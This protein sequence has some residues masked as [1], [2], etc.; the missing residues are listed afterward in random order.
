MSDRVLLTGSTGYLGRQLLERLETLGVEVRTL[1]R[2]ERP[3]A[4]TLAWSPGVNSQGGATTLIHLAGVA[5]RTNCSQE[6]CA[7]AAQFARQAISSARAVSAS[8]A[9]LVSSI[10]ASLAEQGSG[11]TYGAHKLEIEGIFSSEFTGQLITL[12]LPPVYGGRADASSIARLAGLVRRG[13]PLPLGLAGAPRD[14]LS[15]ENFLHLATTLLRAAW[16][17]PGRRDTYEPSDGS[18]VTTVELIRHLGKLANRTPLL[19]PVP[20][21]AMRKLSMLVGRSDLVQAAFDPLEARDNARL[22]RDFGWTPVISMPASLEYLHSA[23]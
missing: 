21:V 22:A 23:T 17:D 3:G 8:R 4:P 19:L 6:T 9:I 5:G 20:P 11:S 14:Y 10:Y 15:I 13:L 12:R 16:S 2:R 7:E 18:A 1:F